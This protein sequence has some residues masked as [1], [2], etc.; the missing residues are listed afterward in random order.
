MTQSWAYAPSWRNA[1]VGTS[2]RPVPPERVTALGGRAPAGVPPAVDAAALR[3]RPRRAL[4]PAAG[5]RTLA[6]L[7]ACGGP[8]R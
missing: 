6:G 2:Q 5:G 4:D 7:L 3:L 1:H 8:L